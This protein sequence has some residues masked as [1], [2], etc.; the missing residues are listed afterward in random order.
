M[1]ELE[2]RR[3]QWI[4]VL[5]AFLFCTHYALAQC[6]FGFRNADE[7]NKKSDRRQPEKIMEEPELHRSKRISVL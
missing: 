2:T 4:F 5:Q 1:E 6:R 7:T 3:F